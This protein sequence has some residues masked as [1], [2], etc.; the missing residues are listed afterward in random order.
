MKRTTWAAFGVALIALASGA[1][2]ASADSIAYVNKTDGNVYLST[3][4]GSRQYQVTSTGGYGD[5]SQ[6]DDGAP[7]TAR[8]SRTRTTT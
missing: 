2:T 7:R 8:R 4:D 3:S 6:A 1:P 5:V